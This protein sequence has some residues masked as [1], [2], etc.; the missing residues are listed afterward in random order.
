MYTVQSHTTTAAACA[1][2]GYTLSH[3]SEVLIM[4]KVSSTVTLVLCKSLE[5]H[6]LVCY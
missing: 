2:F 4:R 3:F 6:M 5:A 1:Q